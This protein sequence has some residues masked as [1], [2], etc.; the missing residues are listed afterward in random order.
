[1]AQILNCTPREIIFT[2]CGSESD[3]LAIRGVAFMNRERGNHIITSPIEHH[4]VSHTGEQLEK[5]F[6]FQIT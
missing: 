3:N 5:H 6:G 1:M 2:S 4:A